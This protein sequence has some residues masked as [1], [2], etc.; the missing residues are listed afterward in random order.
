MDLSWVRLSHKL[1]KMGSLSHLVGAV[2]RP[3]T[4]RKTRE[5]MARQLGCI[6]KGLTGHCAKQRI[7]EVERRG[8]CPV[9]GHKNRLQKRSFNI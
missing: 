1:T 2:E 3:A 7:V 6:Y 5:E 4:A 8:R 9:V